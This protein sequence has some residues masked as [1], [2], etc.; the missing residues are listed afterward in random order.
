MYNILFTS[1]FSTHTST[2]LKLVKDIFSGISG[3]LFVLGHESVHNKKSYNLLNDYPSARVIISHDDSMAGY[4]DFIDKQ[5]TKKKID[6]VI[7]EADF[8][9]TMEHNFTTRFYNDF[10]TRIKSSVILMAKSYSSYKDIGVLITDIGDDEMTQLGILNDLLGSLHAK[11]HLFQI[12]NDSSSEENFNTIQK[13]DALTEKYGIE[14]YSINVIHDRRL[15]EGMNFMIWKKNLDMIAL[16][17]INPLDL[18]NPLLVQEI[19]LKSNVSLYY[20]I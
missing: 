12:L 7:V 15:I 4:I 3:K 10:V 16:L 9:E 13:L 1:N 18:N 14:R 19:L 8:E 2:G 6:I 20:H 17:N 11:L 5:I